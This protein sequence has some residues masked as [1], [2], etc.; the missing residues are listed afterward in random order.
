MSVKLADTLAPMAE[1]PVAMAQDVNIKKSDTE[2]KSLQSMYDNGELGGSGDNIPVYTTEEYEQIKDT[3]PEGTKYII[4]DDYQEEEL[5]RKLINGEIKAIHHRGWSAQAP[6]NTLPAFELSA[7]IGFKY[8]ETDVT[9]TEDGVPILLHDQD[10]DRVTG[11]TLGDIHNLT[12]DEIKD[13][14]FSKGEWGSSKVNRWNIK[15][16]NV[17][18][19]TFEEFIKFCHVAGLHPYIELNHW[20]EDRGWRMTKEQAKMLVDIV[21]KYHME[22]NV[23]W[24]SF[25]YDYLLYVREYDRYARLGYLPDVVDSDVLNSVNALKNGVNDVFLDLNYP[26]ATSEVCDT[27]N[28]LSIPL[29]VY[30]LTAIS[31]AEALHP[32]ISGVTSDKDVKFDEVLKDKYFNYGDDMTGWTIPQSIVNSEY[33]ETSTWYATLFKKGDMVTATISFTI[34]KPNGNITTPITDTNRIKEKYVPYK[35]PSFS[36]PCYYT[37]DNGTPKTSV[38]RMGIGIKGDTMPDNAG[39]VVISEW[40]DVPVGAK[41]RAFFSY[42]VAPLS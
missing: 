19:P 16:S 6:E 38:L 7:K 21:K 29:E 40:G 20:H 17:K 42:S 27:C 5:K 11:T 34:K 36:V 31:Q 26:L 39:T 12:Y 3:I 4:S 37:D 41:C 14:D 15:F 28:A 30:T 10:V 9:F 32:Y 35:Y 18:V 24:I 33:V 23:T 8:V 22:N 2:E 25:S 1:F 13:L